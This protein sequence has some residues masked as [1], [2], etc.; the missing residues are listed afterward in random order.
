MSRGAPAAGRSSKKEAAGGI[1]GCREEDA[2]EREEEA[3]TG[4]AHGLPRCSQERKRRKGLELLL[5]LCVV[6][7]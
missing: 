1:P 4:G 7:G 3:L 2:R 5:E 6:N